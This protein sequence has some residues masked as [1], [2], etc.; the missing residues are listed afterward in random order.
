MFVFL[1]LEFRIHSEPDEK[2]RRK[3]IMKSKERQIC[4][5]RGD[6]GDRGRKR[7]QHDAAP[8][9]QGKAIYTWGVWGA[10][11]IRGSVQRE[12]TGWPLTVV[13]LVQDATGFRHCFGEDT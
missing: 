6:R 7:A 3:V 13:A 9:P 8:S 2:Q 5:H 1:V 4:K 11:R 12:R 10:P